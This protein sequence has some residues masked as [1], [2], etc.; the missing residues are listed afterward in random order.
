[1]CAVL[2]EMVI[3]SGMDVSSWLLVLTVASHTL[4]VDLPTAG[5][6]TVPRRAALPR[7]RAEDASTWCARHVTH[8]GGVGVLWHEVE[9]AAI[10][11]AVD[12]FDAACR[13]PGG[14]RGRCGG[15]GSQD[16]SSCFA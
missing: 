16:E 5:G 7:G 12:H 3:R 9:I 4:A 8:R 6:G 13:D 15:I 10:T 2:V 14:R 11:I 1:M